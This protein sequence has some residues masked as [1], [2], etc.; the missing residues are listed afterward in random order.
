M[1]RY[2]DEGVEGLRSRTSQG[3]PAALNDE[4]ME[5]LRII[6]LEGPDPKRDGVIR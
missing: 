2:N 4:Q 3:R 6:E 1:H 5:A